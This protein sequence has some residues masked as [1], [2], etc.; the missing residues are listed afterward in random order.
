MKQPLERLLQQVAEQLVR[1]K[2]RIVF[3]ESC[4]G[5]LISATLARSP[6]ISIVHCGSA[7]VYRLETKTK[8]LGVP[9]SMLIDPGPVSH[10]VACAM[11]EGVL[12]MTPEAVLAVSI[13]GHLGPDAP[14]HQDG[15]VFL[16]VA[17]RGKSCRAIEHQLP[18][19]A[20]ESNPST[21]PGS[22]AREQRQWAAVEMAFSQILE[23][24]SQN[25]F[26]R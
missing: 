3:A 14:E 22:T 21:S 1:N 23:T 5:G 20:G 9:A 6:G 10:A 15:L 18:N 24:I 2:I 11:A 13:T 4:T 16:G 17:I 12:N 8:W 7:V 26:G 19:F 25:E